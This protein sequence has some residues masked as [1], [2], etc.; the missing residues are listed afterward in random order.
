MQ[1]SIGL[2]PTAR[3]QADQRA[4]QRSN[5]AKPPIAQIHDSIAK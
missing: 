2:M 4:K 3:H 1:W 5:F